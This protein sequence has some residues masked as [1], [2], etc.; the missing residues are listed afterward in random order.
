MWYA[1]TI[2]LFVGPFEFRKL[3]LERPKAKRLNPLSIFKYV[4]PDLVFGGTD[5]FHI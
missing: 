4:Q 5:V 1:F 2:V 3:R